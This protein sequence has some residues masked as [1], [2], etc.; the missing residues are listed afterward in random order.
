[1]LWK[2]I[3]ISLASFGFV[4]LFISSKAKELNDKY[5]KEKK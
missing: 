2:I 3:I 4:Y 1:M 5:E